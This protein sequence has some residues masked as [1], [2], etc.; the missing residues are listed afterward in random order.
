MGV[1]WK[2]GGSSFFFVAEMLAKGQANRKQSKAKLQRNEVGIRDDLCPGY[3]GGLPKKVGRRIEAEEG[4]KQSRR[5][6]LGPG[7]EWVVPRLLLPGPSE[8]D[9]SSANVVVRERRG[10]R[11]DVNT[12]Q[13]EKGTRGQRDE[14]IR[15]SRR[16]TGSKMTRMMRLHE[17]QR[18]MSTASR[19][20]AIEISKRSP[21]GQGKW[22][23]SLL[24]SYDM[25]S[26]S[27]SSYTRAMLGCWAYGSLGCG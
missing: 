26:S 19:R 14:K 13:G 20:D 16:R 3:S 25:S 21:Q 27:T 9:T 2:E 11:S 1:G 17:G 18:A 12:W 6:P 7:Q 23:T 4:I 22:K 10:Q 8:F 5:P 15:N 24:S